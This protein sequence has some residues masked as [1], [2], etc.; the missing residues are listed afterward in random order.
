M[1][2]SVALSPFF[3]AGHLAAKIT[4]GVQDGY[5]LCYQNAASIGVLFYL[6]IGL[7]YLRKLLLNY[8]SEKITALTLIAVILGTNLLWYASFEGLMPHAISFSLLCVCLY[9][10]YEWLKA[11]SRKHLLVFAAMFGLSI[12]IRPLA[13]TIGLYFLVT[14][15]LSKGGFSRFWQF[16]KPQMKSVIVS[17]IIIVAIASLQL[18]YWKY[19]TG[20]WI[21]D[22]YIDEHFVFSSPQMLPFLFSFRKGLF[23]YTPILFFAVIGLIRLYKTHR[24]I[25]YGTVILMPVT[26]FLLSSWWAW[27]YGICWGMRPAIDYYS[28]LSIPLASGFAWVFTKKRLRLAA[29]ILVMLLILLNL[30]QTWQYKNGLIHYDDM[31]R[32]AYF[33]GFFQTKASPEWQDLLRPYDWD[34]RISG[35]P[36]VENYRKYFRES[37]GTH[38]VYFRGCNMQYVATNPKAQNAVAAYAKEPSSRLCEFR[39]LGNEGSVAIFSGDDHFISVSREYDNVLIA[40]ASRA[41][42]NEQFEIIYLEDDDNRIALKSLANGKYVTVSPEFPNI[43]FATADKIGRNETFRLFVGGLQSRY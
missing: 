24:A 43:V 21:Y 28:L 42:H 17:L 35:L 10:F 16:L 8:F 20:H 4:G 15:I 23:V 13:L 26:V 41:D 37:Y 36:Q 18:M 27:S 1:G 39:I 40:N 2:I 6:F 34:R 32:K 11:G 12:L 19:A 38:Y 22:V 3:L 9:H 14:A 31:T 33:K 5:S 7:F 25:F 29:A 30:F